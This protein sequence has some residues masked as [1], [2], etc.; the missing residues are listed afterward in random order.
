M[1]FSGSWNKKLPLIVFSYNNKYQ[2]SIGVALY[3]AVYGRKCQSLVQWYEFGQ[4]SLQQ[5]N[6]MKE[7]TE[8]MKKIRQRLEIAQS[9]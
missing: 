5:T 7:T 3:K 8:A 9:R 2:T 1:D 4:S 6:F